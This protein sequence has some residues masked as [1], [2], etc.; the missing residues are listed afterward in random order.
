M[1]NVGARVRVKQVVDKYPIGIVPVGTTGIV[2]YNDGV[3]VHVLMDTPIAGYE[4][5]NN[6]VYFDADED[7][8]TEE[9]LAS[10]YLEVV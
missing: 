10:E 5:W 2:T 4:E 9:W 7:A 1:F 3:I 8:L 6:E